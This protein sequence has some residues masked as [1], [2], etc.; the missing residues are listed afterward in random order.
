MSDGNFIYLFL[1]KWDVNG[2]LWYVI[3]TYFDFG[4]GSHVGSDPGIF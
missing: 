1:N 4:V 3:S 2:N